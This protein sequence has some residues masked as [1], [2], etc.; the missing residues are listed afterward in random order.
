MTNR[1]ALLSS[2]CFTHGGEIRGAARDKTGKTAVGLTYLDLVPLEKKLLF[3]KAFYY[4][5]LVLPN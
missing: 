2:L 4:S 1:K 5:I 3:Q